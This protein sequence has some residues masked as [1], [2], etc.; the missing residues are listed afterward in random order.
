MASR[1]TSDRQQIEDV[2]G[3]GGRLM[4]VVPSA[5]RAKIAAG[6]SMVDFQCSMFDDRCSMFG[7]RGLIFD[8]RCSI[9]FQCSMFDVRFSMFGVR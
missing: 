8:V 3:S 1:A 7:V 9:D 5:Y 2:D 4:S 6:I